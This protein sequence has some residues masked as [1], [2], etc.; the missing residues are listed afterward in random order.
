MQ[1]FYFHLPLLRLTPAKCKVTL[2][3]LSSVFTHVQ[4]D[5]KQIETAFIKIH[6]EQI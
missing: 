6:R 5:I 1:H 3:A 4:S 2:S